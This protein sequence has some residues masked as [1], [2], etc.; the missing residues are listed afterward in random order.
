MMRYRVQLHNSNGYALVAV[1]S[2]GAFASIFLLALALMTDS[3]LRS[4]IFLTERSTLLNAAE[5]GLD[6]AVDDLNKGIASTVEPRGS[7]YSKVTTLS[8][9][10][11]P[12][13]TQGVT[14]NIRVRRITSDA[15]NPDSLVWTAMKTQPNAILSSYPSIDPDYKSSAYSEIPLRIIEVTASKGAL[16]TSIRAYALWFHPLIDPT[17]PI[18]SIPAEAQPYFTSGLMA[19]SLLA[20]NDTSDGDPAGIQIVEADQGPVFDAASQVENNAFKLKLTTNGEANLGTNAMI[21]GDLAITGPTNGAPATVAQANSPTSSMLLGRLTSNTAVDRLDASTNPTGSIIATDNASLP[22]IS[23]DN[24]LSVA[25]LFEGDP[26]RQGA[27]LTPVEVVSTSVDQSA[28]VPIPPPEGSNP[29]P[30]FSASVGSDA[31]L[32]QA[33]YKTTSLNSTNSQSSLQINQQTKIFVTDDFD[34]S[35]DAI[36]LDSDKLVNTTGDAKN[37]Q[38]FYGGKE[39]VT[40]NLKSST[41]FTGLVYAPNAKVAIVGNGDFIG[42]IVGD[43]VFVNNTGVVRLQ[44]DINTDSSA[45]TYVKIAGGPQDYDPSAYTGVA[46]RLYKIVSW[47]QVN[48]KLVP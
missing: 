7:E 43:K 6:Y 45:P 9:S 17:T 20:F 13:A 26:G 8:S 23:T 4:E 12:S 11:L 24:V 37:M 46:Q 29:L 38:I 48:Q 32:S 1:L 21:W 14:V 5:I 10:Y 30:S 33:T 31:Q 19:N 44:H 47:Q 16:A 27:N 28:T 18:G 2:I 35:T 40:I 15:S 39:D 3:L 42:A 34:A 25:D 36:N 41:P 22:D